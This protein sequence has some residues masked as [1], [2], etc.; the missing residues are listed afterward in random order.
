MIIRKGTHKSWQCP[1]LILNKDIISYI[2]RF[3]DSCRYNIGKDQGDI[4]KLFGIAYFP[5]HHKNSVR[6]G[7]NY[8]PETNKIRLYAY[9][10]INGVRGWHYMHSVKIGKY[11]FITIRIHRP[12][13]FIDI[14]GKKFLVDCKGSFGYLLGPYFGGNQTA[15]HDINI[16]IRRLK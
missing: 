3:D 8:Q 6:I 11:V 15:P 9:W 2:V 4:N 16:E 10:Y 13:H 5:H 14:Q 7:W 12:T 1:E